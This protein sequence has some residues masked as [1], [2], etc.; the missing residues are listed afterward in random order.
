[1]EAIL[2]ILAISIG[3]SFLCSLFEAPLYVVTLTR[4]EELRR[5]GP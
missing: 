3:G 5:R 4:V 1:M 2:I